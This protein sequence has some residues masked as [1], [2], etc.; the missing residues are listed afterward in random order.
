MMLNNKICNI[1]GNTRSTGL[2]FCRVDVRQEP[3]IV[4]VVMVS[5]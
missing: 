4:I 1:C 3:H 2:K 5:P